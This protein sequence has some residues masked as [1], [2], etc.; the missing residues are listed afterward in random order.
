MG[1]I[2]LELLYFLTI[3]SLG[4]YLERSKNTGKIYESLSN[5]GVDV[6]IIYA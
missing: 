6:L 1:I 5:T 3:S 2:V 4:T